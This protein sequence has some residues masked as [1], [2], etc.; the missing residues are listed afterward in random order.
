M[1]YG[2]MDDDDDMGMRADNP[3]LV[4]EESVVSRMPHAADVREAAEMMVTASDEKADVEPSVDNDE[5]T[6]IESAEEQ[7][8]AINETQQD[9]LG[10]TAQQ[11]AAAKSD[12]DTVS[13][14]D[15][16][17]NKDYMV[18]KAQQEAGVE[19][20]GVEPDEQQAAALSLIHI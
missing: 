17:G 8:S 15:F 16:M 18:N 14:E 13:F 2:G 10:G 1:W 4:A 19:A 5:A 6:D 20:A 7:D 12:D 11:E 9:T 3:I